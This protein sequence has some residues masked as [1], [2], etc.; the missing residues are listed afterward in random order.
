M[1]TVTFIDTS[2]L[3]EVLGVPGKSQDSDGVRTQLRERVQAGESLVLPAACIIETGNH[4]AQL[5]SGDARRM[6]AQHFAKLLQSTAAE[7]AP[8]VVNGARW[9]GELLSAMCAG[10]RGCPP[11]PEM[12]M[13][14]VG[15]GD[16][17]ILAEADAYAQRVRHVKVTIWTREAA[18]SAYA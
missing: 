3:V 10:T 18:L 8:W 2:V 1:R 16:I 7:T 6:Y 17:S 11:M 5:P 9:D 12:A 13:Q 4:I 14:G 15:A